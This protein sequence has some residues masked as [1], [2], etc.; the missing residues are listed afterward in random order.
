VGRDAADLVLDEAAKH[1]SVDGIAFRRR[2]GSAARASEHRRCSL[3][4]LFSV[5]PTSC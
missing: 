2:V 3:G 5:L 1:G 4:S